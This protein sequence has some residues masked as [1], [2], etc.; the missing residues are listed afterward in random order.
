MRLYFYHLILYC[1][2]IIFNLL[3][4]DSCWCLDCEAIAKEGCEGHNSILDPKEDVK[5]IK[6][7]LTE[8]SKHSSKAVEKRQQIDDFLR[9]AIDTNGMG[10]AKLFSLSG[11]NQLLAGSKIGAVSAKNNLKTIHWKLKSFK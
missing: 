9:A 6:A 11:V 7:L 3:L 1:L 10:L 5:E 8:F 2:E 4:N